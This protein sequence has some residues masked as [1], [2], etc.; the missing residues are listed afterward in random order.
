MN[1]YPRAAAG[2]SLVE[3]ALAM[4][5]AVFCL[6]TVFG[7]LPVGVNT[8]RG[9][10]EQ[11]AAVNI[12]SGIIADLRAAYLISPAAD[13]TSARYGIT[14]PAKPPVPPS[15]SSDRR[16]TVFLSEDGSLVGKADTSVSGGAAPRYRVTVY[17]T[18]TNTTSANSVISTRVLVTWP[19]V[20]D[21]SV[22]ADPK[23]FSG[24]Y[25]SLAALVRN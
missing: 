2:F 15:T 4:G 17:F 24:S 8:N 12:A 19:A 3:V 5:I 9:S 16:H 25:E 23:R 13:Q 6:V 10:F 7:L 22:D 11:T 21:P 14:I 1:T 20:S 18:A